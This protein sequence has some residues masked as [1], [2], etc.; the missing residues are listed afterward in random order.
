MQQHDHDQLLKMYIHQST[1]LFGIAGYQSSQDALTSP[2]AFSPPPT[3]H[4]PLHVSKLA[5]AAPAHGGLLSAQSSG[6]LGPYRTDSADSQSPLLSR[7]RGNTSLTEAELAEEMGTAFFAPSA[8]QAAAQ[9]TIMSPNVTKRELGG[10]QNSM[11]NSPPQQIPSAQIEESVHDI[12]SQSQN[13]AMLSGPPRQIPTAPVLA[14]IHTS[15][16]HPLQ[17]EGLSSAEGSPSSSLSP[18]PK[19]RKHGSTR[20]ALNESGPAGMLSLS[21]VFMVSVF[22]LPDENIDCVESPLNRQQEK[23]GNACLA[24]VGS[25]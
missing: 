25:G 24:L 12:S 9:Q 21:H 19:Q 18:S 8:Q 6:D 14:A 2:N 17:E 1:T 15:S 11:H 20:F 5:S 4:S 3:L 7:L 10:K 22:V 13:E 16:S 23:Y